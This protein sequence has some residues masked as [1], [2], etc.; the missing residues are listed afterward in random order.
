MRAAGKFYGQT[1]VVV[2]IGGIG[3]TVIKR[4]IYEKEPRT[5]VL[6]DVVDVCATSLFWPVALPLQVALLV[7]LYAN[8][9]KWTIARE[10]KTSASELSHGKQ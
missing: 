8:D 10:T 3:G 6:F 9:A 2:A 4:K 5:T 7:D 1:M